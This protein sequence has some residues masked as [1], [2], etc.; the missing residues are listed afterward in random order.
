MGSPMA[1]L[2]IHHNATVTVCHSRTVDLPSVVGG[3]GMVV[4]VFLG[5]L[6]FLFSFW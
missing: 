1:Q 6:V 2:L 5:G 3:G 4:F